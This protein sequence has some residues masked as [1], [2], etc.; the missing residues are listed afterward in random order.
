MTDDDQQD[1]PLAKKRA[2]L[3]ETLGDIAGQVSD[4]AIAAVELADRT[5]DSLQD[6]LATLNDDATAALGTVIRIVDKQIADSD[7]AIRIGENRVKIVGD[8][9]GLQSIEAEL[10]DALEGTDFHLDYD[11]EGG[12]DIVLR[13]A[14]HDTGHDQ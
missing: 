8:E 9:T 11:R 7:I 12:I 5:A 1:K 4:R 2:A 6:R 10:Q 3:R 14:D 13:E